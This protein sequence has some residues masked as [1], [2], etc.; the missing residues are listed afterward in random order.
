MLEM[1]TTGSHASSQVLT[2]HLHPHLVGRRNLSH[3]ERHV[4][5]ENNI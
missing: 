4:K 3:I 5:L 2:Q 1:T